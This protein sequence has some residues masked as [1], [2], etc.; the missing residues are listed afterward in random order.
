MVNCISSR[1]NLGALVRVGGV[2]MVRVV[3]EDAIEGNRALDRVGEDEAYCGFEPVTG[4]VDG[5]TEFSVAC[6]IEMVAPA[7]WLA[8]D[9]AEKKD[10]RMGPNGRGRT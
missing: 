4:A 9:L 7:S 5:V 1:K 3:E 2:E 8:A 10:G 6:G